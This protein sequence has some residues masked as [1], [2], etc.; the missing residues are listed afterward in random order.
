MQTNAE[1]QVYASMDLV[2][3]IYSFGT[4]G[5]RTFTRHLKL[6][7]RCYP[8]LLREKYYSEKLVHGYVSC[9]MKEYLYNYSTGRLIRY[10]RNFKR[11]YCCTRHS[12]DLPMWINHEIVLTGPSVFENQDSEDSEC[13]CCCRSLSRNIMRNLEERELVYPEALSP[14]T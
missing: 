6:D 14:D 1:Q 13:E 7:L 8:E 11:C 5:H 9:S 10:L 2:R 3:H 4:P 12:T